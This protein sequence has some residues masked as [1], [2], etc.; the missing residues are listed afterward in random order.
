MAEIA[1]DKNKL[2]PEDRDRLTRSAALIGNPLEHDHPLKDNMF[3]LGRVT[4]RRE[5]VT[6]DIDDDTPTATFDDAVVDA[7][8][9]VYGRTIP[10]I[11]DFA[12]KRQ[13][14]PDLTLLN[15]GS[16]IWIKQEGI[17]RLA[18]LQRQIYKMD[19]EELGPVI[20]PGQYITPVGRADKPNL[21]VC[22]SE[23]AEELVLLVTPGT[24]TAAFN[25]LAKGRNVDAVP[26]LIS[27]N[28]QTGVTPD[29]KM[30]IISKLRQKLVERGEG[31]GFPK[32]LSDEP[33]IINAH[34][35]PEDEAKL[36]IV[37]TRI[38]GSL[39]EEFSAVAFHESAA[40]SIQFNIPCEIELL[41]GL[42]VLAFNG[43]APGRKVALMT[44]QEIK[45]EI[46]RK[47]DN[48]EAP[49]GI[50]VFNRGYIGDVRK[51]YFDNDVP[52]DLRNKN[53]RY[54]GPFKPL[55]EEL[56]RRHAQAMALK[57]A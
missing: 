8:R 26:L 32:T 33:A 38:N 22:M 1:F 50:F 28:G 10:T 48:P 31:D 7:I 5:L 3:T 47:A 52:S 43:E 57:S 55:Q 53:G 17:S 39:I 23:G 30:E 46:R 20:A 27:F 51:D 2:V 18:L 56:M 25:A 24:N 9:T 6:V 37:Q 29:E 34:L 49:G 14:D 45:E 16:M 4:R 12:K 35:R 15:G 36:S 19:K 42:K 44:Q 11:Y 41:P 54:E 40:S 13:H 21:Q